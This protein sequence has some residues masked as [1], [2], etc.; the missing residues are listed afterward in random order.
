MRLRTVD[1]ANEFP[2]FPLALSLA[3]DMGPEAGIPL[4]ERLKDATPGQDP[5]ERAVAETQ[6]RHATAFA[7]SLASQVSAGA[8]THEAALETIRQK[9][10]S[11]DERLANRLR[12]HGYFRAR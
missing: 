9:Y 4:R 10:P 3:M 11:L 6:A 7:E 12:S 8:L 5:Y 1:M 2:L